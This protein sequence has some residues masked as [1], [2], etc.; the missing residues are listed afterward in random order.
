MRR[1]S[2]ASQY[3]RIIDAFIQTLGPASLAKGIAIKDA[4]R[5][6]SVLKSPI[7]S[8]VNNFVILKKL[9]E[10]VDIDGPIIDV[11]RP[12]INS[13][14]INGQ[15]YKEFLNNINLY[16]FHKNN[17]TTHTIKDHERFRQ[18]KE[19]VEKIDS[20]IDNL[21][22]PGKTTPAPATPSKATPEKVEPEKPV[23]PSPGK[24]DAD[25]LDKADADTLQTSIGKLKVAAKNLKP[26]EEIK[27]SDY[28]NP[29]Q[30]KNLEVKAAIKNLLKE[31][32]K[33][34]KSGFGKNA[35]L[36]MEP[37]AFKR[38][39]KKRIWWIIITKLLTVGGFL[40]ADKL[41]EIWREHVGMMP[42]EFGGENYDDQAVQP[43]S[44]DYQYNDQLS[45]LIGTSSSS[46]TLGEPSASATFNGFIQS[47][48]QSW[49]KT[50]TY[51]DD[52]ISDV[53]KNEDET[54][55]IKHKYKKSFKTL[56]LSNRT[57]EKMSSLILSMIISYART[58]RTISLSYVGK[59]IKFS[60]DL[61]KII[62][63]KL[64]GIDYEPIPA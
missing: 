23:T 35:V 45:E 41:L 33:I 46:P 8:I 31:D 44:S 3:K 11:L 55:N 26:G 34:V 13:G 15:N 30:F 61:D 52:I 36:K 14:N 49:N 5:I 59:M 38:F 6:Q 58:D 29:D 32:P 21:P 4:K 56:S 12:E 54:Y 47:S 62:K 28:I 37:N 57:L 16:L 17:K 39:I 19:I 1:F 43:P 9:D 50:V 22:K 53:T 60:N 63:Q 48:Q 2:S 25:G 27:L 51:L 24:A 40:L 7:E 42:S 10:S 20:K 18:A 64:K